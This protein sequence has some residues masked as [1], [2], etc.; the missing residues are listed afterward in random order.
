MVI[1][2]KKGKPIGELVK[3][4]NKIVSKKSPGLQSSMYSGVL[5]TKIDPIAYQKNI[6]GEWE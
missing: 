6:R 5:K 2:I 4:L 3:K 1:V